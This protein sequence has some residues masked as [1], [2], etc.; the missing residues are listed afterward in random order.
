M[1]KFIAKLNEVKAFK[2]ILNKVGIEQTVICI[3]D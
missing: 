2:I 3:K 1:L